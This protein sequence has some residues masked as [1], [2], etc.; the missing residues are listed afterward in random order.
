MWQTVSGSF[1]VG[2]V[3]GSPLPGAEADDDAAEG[4]RE[5]IPSPTDIPES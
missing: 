4:D 3:L 2:L 5:T 1:S